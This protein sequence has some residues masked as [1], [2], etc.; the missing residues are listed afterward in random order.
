MSTTLFSNSIQYQNL[1]EDCQFADGRPVMSGIADL[2]TT[3]IKRVALKAGTTLNCHK[4]SDHVLVVW[5]RG[6]A[7]FTANQEEFAMH[8]GSLLEM[9]SGTPHGAEAETDCVFAVFKF[10]TASAP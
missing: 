2:G 4:T 9:P 3:Q 10:K 7:R 8:P 1:L 5:L 6:K